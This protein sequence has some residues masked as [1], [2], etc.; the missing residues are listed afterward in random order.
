VP[1]FKVSYQNGETQKVTAREHRPDGDLWII[2]SDSDG[3]VLRIPSRDIESV[4]REGVP[5]REP[6]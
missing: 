1:E 3:I 6:S 4:A 5:D 2:F